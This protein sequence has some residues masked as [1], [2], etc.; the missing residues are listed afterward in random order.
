MEG[1]PEGVIE[2]DQRVHG[3][4]D[5]TGV[6][7]GPVVEGQGEEL[8]GW[9]ELVE[10]GRIEVEVGEVMMVMSWRGVCITSRMPDQEI[11]TYT[12]K[13]MYSVYMLLYVD[14]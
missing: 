14:L 3:E 11:L 7:P 12:H 8:G 4:I 13:C 9:L 1:G 2:I 10:E 6:Y 5:W